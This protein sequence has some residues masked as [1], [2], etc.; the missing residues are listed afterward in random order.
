MPVVAPTGE[1][2]PLASNNKG[3][4]YYEPE[5]LKAS[6]QGRTIVFGAQWTVG[7]PRLQSTK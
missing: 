4:G 2:F 6:T 1:F 3:S 7:D 5:Y